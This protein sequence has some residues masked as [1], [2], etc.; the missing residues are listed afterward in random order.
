MSLYRV[1]ALF[2]CVV[3]RPV[4]RVGLLW[5]ACSSDHGPTNQQFGCLMLCRQRVIHQ[6][7]DVESTDGGGTGICRSGMDERSIL[8]KVVFIPLCLAGLGPFLMVSRDSA[9]A[10]AERGQRA[11]YNA[12]EATSRGHSTSGFHC[13]VRGGT[14]EEDRGEHQV[15]GSAEC[16]RSHRDSDFREFFTVAGCCGKENEADQEWQ[17][18]STGQ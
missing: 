18:K 4:V 2:V 10:A 17:E 6:V 11:C 7:K 16:S 15:S 3:S 5:G 13:R 9:A 12:C 14:G 8:I 1:R